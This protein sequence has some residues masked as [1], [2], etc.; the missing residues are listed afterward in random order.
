MKE[1]PLMETFN[2]RNMNAIND[3]R[4][5][6]YISYAKVMSHSIIKMVSKY[7]KVMFL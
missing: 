7:E 3:G 2:T 5:A 1:N 6:I 4:Y